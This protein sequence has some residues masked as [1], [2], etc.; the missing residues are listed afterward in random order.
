MSLLYS[1]IQYQTGDKVNYINYELWIYRSE[2]G[3]KKNESYEAYIMIILF[4]TDM[5]YRWCVDVLK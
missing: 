2:V 5:C 4:Y 3:R 1:H